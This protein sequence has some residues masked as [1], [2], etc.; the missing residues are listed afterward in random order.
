MAAFS[1]SLPVSKA[2]LFRYVVLPVTLVGVLWTIFSLSQSEPAAELTPSRFHPLATVPQVPFTDGAIKPTPQSPAQWKQAAEDVK[3]AFLHAYRSYETRASPHDE[4]RPLTGGAV[5]NF[6]GWGVSVFDSL[7]TMLLMDLKEEYTRALEIVKQANFSMPKADE[8]ARKLSPAFNT[9]SGLPTFEAGSA[10]GAPRSMSGVLAEVASCM[11]EY[12]YLGKIT[13]NKEYYDQAAMIMHRLESAN[14][15]ALGG[16]LPTSWDLKF[17]RPYDTKLTVGGQADSGHEYLLKQYLL[18]GRSEKPALEMYLRTTTHIITR[19]LHLSSHRKLLW[20]T[21]LTGVAPNDVPR[22][23]HEHLSCFL[24]GL[25]A[26]GVKTLPLDNLAAEGIDFASLSI[27]LSFEGQKEYE[28]LKNYKLSDLHLWAAEGMAE[29][30]NALYADSPTGLSPDEVMIHYGAN[31]VRWIDALEDWRMGGKNG[32]V[33]GTARITPI[34]HVPG[35][36]L[37]DKDYS[38]GRSAYEMRP[39][40]LESLYILWCATGDGR[41]RKYGW[42]IFQA[43]ETNAKVEMGYSSLH[44]SDHLPPSRKDSMPSYFFAETLKYLYLLFTDEDLLPLD[45]WVF[46]TEGHPLPI[47]TWSADEKQTFGLDTML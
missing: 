36:K 15:S 16:M 17:G 20:P 19:M 46:N 33:P 43:I 21:Q 1:H 34:P 8:L 41:W 7:D 5:D 28:L 47:F 37:P 6:N 44:Y 13:G 40:L 23:A 9:S 25:F 2:L 26:L 29:A 10:S 42:N 35:Q 31:S 12:T 32:P 27:D 45:K 24:P 14:L 38:I 18:T 30:C 22:Y 39:E 11:P 4:L 3:A